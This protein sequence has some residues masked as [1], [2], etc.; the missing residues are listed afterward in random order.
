MIFII[1]IIIIVVVVVVVVA[2]IIIIII[3][4]LYITMADHDILETDRARFLK[5]KKWR[6]EFG[7]KSS[8]T[9]GGF[10]CHFLK[11]YSSV[12]LEI[13]YNDSLQQC[14]TSSIG[15][16][17][18]KKFGRSNLGQPKSGRKLGFLSISSVLFISL[19]LNC[20]GSE[21]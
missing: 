2:V 10:F 4:I 14:L 13:A 18:T 20:R 11:F 8:P 15:K 12:F 6:P 5:K 1:I 16:T 19:P 3:L 17:H 7:S 21:L 9:L